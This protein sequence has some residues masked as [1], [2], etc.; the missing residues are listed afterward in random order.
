MRVLSE[1]VGFLRENGRFSVRISWKNTGNAS[2][3]GSYAGLEW[4]LA[5][6]PVAIGACICRFS[7]E[8]R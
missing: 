6:V 8:S 7:S 3:R 5:V 4:S 2:F 1:S